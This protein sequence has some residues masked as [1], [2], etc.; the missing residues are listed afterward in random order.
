[1]KRYII[2]LFLPVALLTACQNS[3]E[4]DMEELAEQYEVGVSILVTDAHEDLEGTIPEFTYEYAEQLFE[5]LHEFVTDEASMQDGD[6]SIEPEL[7]EP[8]SGE[9]TG[10]THSV[11]LESETEAT[12]DGFMPIS[13]VVAFAYEIEE[14]GIME[15]IEE[16]FEEINPESIQISQLGAFRDGHGGMHFE[17]SQISADFD[18]ETREITFVV[19]GMWDVHFLYE[20][21]EVQFSVADEWLVPLAEDEVLSFY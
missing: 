11:K 6:F 7:M 5:Y 2:P 12:A 18:E 3:P 15:V 16:E 1:M 21:K 8:V 19:T 9:T 20:G 13:R 4:E 14:V 10:G 17:E